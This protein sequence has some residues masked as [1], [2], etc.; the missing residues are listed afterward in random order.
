MDE[1]PGRRPEPIR[2]IPVRHPGRWV[3]VAVIAVLTA[4]FVH[5]LVT[6]K[7]F[8]WHFV[9]V[10]IGP[11]QPGLMF[12]EPVL[13]GL[14]TTLL[15]TVVSMV[16]GVALGLVLAVM[17]LSENP[18][19]RTVAFAYTWFFRGIPRIVLMV[20]FGDLGILWDR[21][22]LGVPF[23]HQLGLLFGI[24]DLNTEFVSIKATDLLAGFTAAIF[25]LGLSEAAYMAEIVR[26][27]MQ[28]VDTGQNEASTALGLSRGQ[29]LWRIVLPQAMRVI[30]P[31]T[32]NETIAMVKD[33]ALASSVPVT[34]E[35]FF[36]LRAVGARTFQV[37]PYLVAATLWYLV[38]CS[39]LMIGQY[40][41]ERY[42]G[43]GYGAQSAPRARASVSGPLAPPRESEGATR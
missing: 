13:Q 31:P 38:L 43:R 41:I 40:Y 36:Q 11:G 12:T 34:T 39:I 10:S 28:S 17:R 16:V 19:L 18:I 23:D 14:R 21:V 26:A 8:N 24:H 37:V 22:G 30:V 42:F 25:A 5:L 33:T 32:G 3:A 9:F 29:T 7:F 15:M 4:M 1:Q 20:L 6:N 35:L 2:A 27:G